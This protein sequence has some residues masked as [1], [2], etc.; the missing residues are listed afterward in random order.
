ALAFSPLFCAAAGEDFIIAGDLNRRLDLELL[1]NKSPDLWPIVTG[2]ETAKAGD[3][4]ALTHLPPGETTATGK[5]CWSDQ[6]PQERIAIDYFVLS[7]GMEPS[8]AH[9]KLRKGLCTEIK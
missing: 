9:N 1:D 8:D 2:S 4:I 3:D 6:P 7:P 5:A